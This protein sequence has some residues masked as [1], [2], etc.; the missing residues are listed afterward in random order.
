MKEATKSSP[1][2]IQRREFETGGKTASG[3]RPT[4]AELP[5]LFIALSIF[6]CKG[7]AAYRNLQEG[8]EKKTIRLTKAV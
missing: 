6:A 8:Q 2:S 5:D 7:S 3:S 4:E 1:T